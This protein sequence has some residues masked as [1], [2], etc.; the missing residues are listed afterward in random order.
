MIPERD[1]IRTCQ[2][3]QRIGAPI[4]PG[5]YDIPPSV[6]AP[7]C[8]WIGSDDPSAKWASGPLNTFLPW[9]KP[10]SV[11][12]DITW[13]PIYNNGS[14]SRFVDSNDRFRDTLHLLADQSFDWVSPGLLRRKLRDARHWE[15]DKAHKALMLDMCWRIWLKNAEIEPGPEAMG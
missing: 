13:S 15:A 8:N 6:G 3:L 2:T 10:P 4:P 14:R 9:M 11:P 12:H 5:F 7:L 1:Y